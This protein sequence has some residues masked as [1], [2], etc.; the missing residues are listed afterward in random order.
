MGNRKPVH[1]SVLNDGKLE[2]FDAIAILEPYIYK[3]LADDKPTQGNHRNWHTFLPTAQRTE[4]H[5]RHSYRA[6]IWVNQTVQA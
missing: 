1:W 2:H 6:A 5:I 4:E 3:D